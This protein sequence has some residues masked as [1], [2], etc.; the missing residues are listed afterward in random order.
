MIQ[1]LFP[2]K[3]CFCQR[4]TDRQIDRQTDRQTDRKID[5]QTDRQIDRKTDRQTDRQTDNFCF[6]VL[7]FPVKLRKPFRKKKFRVYLFREKSKI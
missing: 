3:F 2:E 5:R 7:G 1:I 6:I 4:Q